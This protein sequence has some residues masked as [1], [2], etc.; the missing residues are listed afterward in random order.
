MGAFSYSTVLLLWALLGLAAAV[1]LFFTPAPYGRHERRGWGPRVDSTVGWVLMEAT[2]V[3]V[4]PAVFFA[5]G[6]RDAVSW[7]FLALW[8]LHYLHR[9]FV[10]PFR[11]A[12]P[13]RTPW[14]IVGMAL[15]F[16]VVNGVLNGAYLF[17]L[18]PPYGADWLW[19]PRFLAGL[20]V[21]LGGM[22]LNVDSDNR[23][24]RLRRRSEGYAVPHGG[25][26][27]WVSCPNYLGEI[28]EWTGFAIATASPAAWVFAWWTLANLAPRARS[29]HRWYR[30]RF[31]DYPA[32]RR[33]LV[34][35]V[36]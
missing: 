9:A 3:L 11:R 15:A 32:T 29:H 12:S 23:L 4:L 16:N 18:A 26:F 6:R 25:G 27:R 17:A 34:P 10:F 28:V 1:G 13:R 22:A 36:W 2:A 21:F 35:F 30:E 5:A 8:E 7:V 31:A 33:A 20:A 24:L 19:R 14:A